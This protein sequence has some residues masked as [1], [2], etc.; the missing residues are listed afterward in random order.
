MAA[1]SQRLD[2]CLR[3]GGEGPALW[4][5]RWPQTPAGHS[6][7]L[8]RAPDGGSSPPSAGT[9]SPR[10]LCARGPWPLTSGT[11]TIVTWQ[12]QARGVAAAGGKTPPACGGEGVVTR[13]GKWAGSGRR[14]LAG[15]G[16]GGHRRGQDPDPAPG[17][18]RGAEDAARARNRGAQQASAHR[19]RAAKAVCATA[20]PASRGPSLQTLRSALTT[21]GGRPRVSGGRRGGA[22]PERAWAL[23]HH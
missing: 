14:A 13:A 12:Q 23:L 5:W 20:R 9:T 2:G 18:R 11:E 8:G 6:S 17:R 4:T 10:R 21:T 7:P 3:G 15:S 1:R 22:R 19:C 16:N